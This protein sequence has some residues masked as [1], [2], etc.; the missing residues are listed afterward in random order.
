[1]GVKSSKRAWADII[2]DILTNTRDGENVTDIMY[3][4][5]LS[6]AHMKEYLKMMVENGLL[7]YETE[8][9]GMYRTTE[10]GFEYLETYKRI[11]RLAFPKE[12][13]STRRG[14]P[15]GAA[16]VGEEEEDDPEQQQQQQQR[17][18]PVAPGIAK[19]KARSSYTSKP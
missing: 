19:G 11:R 2:A 12:Q 9:R 10:R 18:Q 7:A 16:R 4:T 14:A 5:R 15:P 13:G 1:M 3:N 6:Y 17:Q 8:G